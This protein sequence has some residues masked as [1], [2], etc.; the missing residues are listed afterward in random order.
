MGERPI[1]L[2]PRHKGSGATE[3]LAVTNHTGDNKDGTKE[4]SC[5]MREQASPAADSK[6]RPCKTIG[7]KERSWAPPYVVSPPRSPVTTPDE[8]KWR[9]LP[10]PGSPIQCNA[11]VRFHNREG[12]KI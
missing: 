7:R 2:T 10:T 3:L 1:P 9:S 5:I 11:I 6:K 8:S 4:A 12:A